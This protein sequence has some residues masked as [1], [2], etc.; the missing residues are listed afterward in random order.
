[1]QRGA[2]DS[3]GG[4]SGNH[5]T[6]LFIRQRHGFLYQHMEAARGSSDGSTGMRDVGRDYDNA[7]YLV[8]EGGGGGGKVGITCC[9][10]MRDT[11][12]NLIQIN[13]LN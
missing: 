4:G 11:G 13:I 9:L 12:L 1:V 7:V 2:K 8:W 10:Y 6:T 5:Q 3:G